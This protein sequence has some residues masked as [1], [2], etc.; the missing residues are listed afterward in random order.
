MFENWGT[1]EPNSDSEDYLQISQAV[2]PDGTTGTW[3][4]LRNSK[5]TNLT[6]IRMEMVQRF[7]CISQPV[8]FGKPIKEI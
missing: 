7:L 5:Q 6:E 3:N 2:Q 8:M 4:D 1:G